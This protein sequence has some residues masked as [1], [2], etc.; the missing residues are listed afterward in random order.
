[1]LEN[2]V[3]GLFSGKYAECNTDKLLEAWE[4]APW[5]QFRLSVPDQESQR[6]D[7]QDPMSVNSSPLGGF[8]PPGLDNCGAGVGGDSLVVLVLLVASCEIVRSY[9]AY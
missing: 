4:I 9:D 7:K 8:K 3:A 6:E 2:R 1:M 5:L